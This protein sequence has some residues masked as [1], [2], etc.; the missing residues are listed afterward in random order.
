[1]LRNVFG[2]AVAGTLIALVLVSAARAAAPVRGHYICWSYDASGYPYMAAGFWIL[3]S[4]R[5]AGEGKKIPGT[6]SVGKKTPK[7]WL[8][9][10]KGSAYG[11]YFG[12]Y[13]T[14]KGTPFIELHNKLG[15]VGTGFPRSS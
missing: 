14:V 11:G 6:Y 8:I 5:Y 4:G 1:M 9:R 13:R 2:A 3:G 15:R 12:Y 7:G 10:F